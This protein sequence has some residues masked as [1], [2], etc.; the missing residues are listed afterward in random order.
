MQ[1]EIERLGLHRCVADLKSEGYA[2]ITDA[3]PAETIAAL[4]D[5]VAAG[6]QARPRVV[7]ALLGTHPIYYEAVLNAKVCALAE[8]TLGQGFLLSSMGSSLVKQVAQ[9]NPSKRRHNGEE[10]HCDQFMVRLAF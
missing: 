2:V 1:P 9:E 8:A 7:T 4:R 6:W 5:V 3:A 10:L